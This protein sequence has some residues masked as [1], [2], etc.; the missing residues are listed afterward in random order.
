MTSRD[1]TECRGAESGHTV[2]TEILPPERGASGRTWGRDSVHNP[3]HVQR[4]HTLP[5]GAMMLR[6]S[7]EVLNRDGR[8]DT[9]AEDEGF[10]DQAEINTDP[11]HAWFGSVLASRGDATAPNDFSPMSPQPSKADVQDDLRRHHP[12]RLPTS[13]HVNLHIR[14]SP[15]R[16]RH[17]QRCHRCRSMTPPHAR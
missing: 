6:Y 10:V 17:D 11:S 16:D 13:N 15:P 5:H 1:Y 14:T 9:R 3:Q 12:R 7:G 4:V 8:Q 2:H